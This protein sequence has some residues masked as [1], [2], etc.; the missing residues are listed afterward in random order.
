MH[1]SSYY[2]VQPFSLPLI[3]ACL[4]DARPN[5]G[6]LIVRRV[7]RQGIERKE[8]RRRDSVTSV[9]QTV[10]FETGSLDKGLAS[11]YKLRQHP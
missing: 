3:S 10:V 6:T 9:S 7:L 8:V 5:Y 1:R 2:R 11:D 4:K